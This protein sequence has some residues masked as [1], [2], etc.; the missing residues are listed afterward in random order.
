MSKSHQPSLSWLDKLNIFILFILNPYFIAKKILVKTQT[1]YPPTSFWL[2]KKMQL[3]FRE[4]SCYNTDYVFYS[5]RGFRS[6]IFTLINGNTRPRETDTESCV[7]L[8]LTFLKKDF[9]IFFKKAGLLQ[10][11]IQRPSPTP[12]GGHD[13]GVWITR[14]KPLHYENWPVSRPRL[15]LLWAELVRPL[16]YKCYLLTNL[17]SQ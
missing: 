7:F 16:I 6:Y 14:S 11:M 1:F 8:I 12:A 10:T 17:D 13:D 15:C 2:L 4:W 9:K 5:P 3:S